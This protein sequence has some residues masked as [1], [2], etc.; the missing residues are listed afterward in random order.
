M[1]TC[2][3]C[4]KNAEPHKMVSCCISSKSFKIECVDVSNTEARKI[5]Q[6]SGLS[7]TCKCCSQVGNDINELKEVTVALQNEIK[8]LKSAIS[9]RSQSPTNSL[10]DIEKIIQEISEREKRKCNIIIYGNNEENN[11]SKDEQSAVDT[12]FVKD[13][14]SSLSVTDNDNIKPIRLGK[15]DATK[16]DRRRPIK[17]ILPSENSVISVLRMSKELKK[18]T[19]FNNI[20]ITRDR[21]PMQ[22]ELYRNTKI[23][24]NQRIANGESNLRIRYDR[25]IPVSPTVN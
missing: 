3:C 8:L 12:V 25:G 6:K 22:L 2:T 17:I 5:H 16:T 18:S 15:F 20:S 9:T 21:T 14:L 11:T 1:N 7:W 23:E 13:V 4:G 24:L 19:R 10:L